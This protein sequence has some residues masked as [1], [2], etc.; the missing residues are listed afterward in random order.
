MNINTNIFINIYF[1]Y[2]NY[3]NF[4]IHITVYPNFDFVAINSE[5]MNSV[6]NK[7]Y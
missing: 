1:V 4:C 2:K 6:Q 3:L 7:L 5:F